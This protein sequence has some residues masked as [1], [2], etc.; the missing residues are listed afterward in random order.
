MSASPRRHPVARLIREPLIH[1]LLLGAAVF[2]LYSFVGTESGVRRAD[3]ILVTQGNLDRLIEAFA[4]T[5]L[6]PPTQADVRGLR[7][8]YVREAAADRTVR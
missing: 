3:T 8:G 7:D 1:F 5:W 4:R 2:A 6:R